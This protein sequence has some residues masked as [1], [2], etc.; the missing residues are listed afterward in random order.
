MR[1]GPPAPVCR[2]TAMSLPIDTKILPYQAIEGIQTPYTSGASSDANT[3]IDED[4]PE[5][6]EEGWETYATESDRETITL[7]VKWVFPK[8][9]YVAEHLVYLIKNN[10]PLPPLTQTLTIQPSVTRDSL[11]SLVTSAFN[12]ASLRADI[13]SLDLF[14]N[15]HASDHTFR[16]VDI[17]EEGDE[18]YPGWDDVQS[19]LWTDEGTARE[20]VYCVLRTSLNRN[21]VAEGASHRAREGSEKKVGRRRDSKM[22]DSSSI[23]S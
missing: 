14:V 13:F 12:L 7:K 3:V 2:A 9:A 16:F 19:A 10:L 17:L 1:T 18:D 23:D 4:D 5:T 21:E 11:V 20:N 22:E 8:T 15:A 6:E